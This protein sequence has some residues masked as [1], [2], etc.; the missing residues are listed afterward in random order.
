MIGINGCGCGWVVEDVEGSERGVT[1]AKRQG[2]SRNR[3]MCVAALQCW[4]V[5]GVAVP[6][7]ILVGLDL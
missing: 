1:C 5:A 6:M 3:R 2:T 7:H 4:H